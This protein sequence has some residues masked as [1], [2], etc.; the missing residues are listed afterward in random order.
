MKVLITGGSGFIGMN[1][2]PG[3]IDDGYQVLNLDLAKPRSGDQ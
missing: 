3:L 2:V 1:L